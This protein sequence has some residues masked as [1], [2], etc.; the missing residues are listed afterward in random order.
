ML[1]SRPEDAL[2]KL[3]KLYRLWRLWRL[4]RLRRLW[5]LWTLWRLWRLWR[6]CICAIL[7]CIAVHRL[8][9]H[10]EVTGRHILVGW[11]NESLIHCSALQ[12]C[13]TLVIHWSYIDNTSVIHWR[14]NAVLALVEI[15]LFNIGHALV[16]LPLR[17]KG[18]PVTLRR[19]NRPA[20]NIIFSSDFFLHNVKF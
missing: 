3:E 12:S 13:N 4:L 1:E 20:R 18:Y 14:Y 16:G 10:W 2:V 11:Y 6:L 5:T 17:S 9:H 8:T 19:S 7:P 15:T